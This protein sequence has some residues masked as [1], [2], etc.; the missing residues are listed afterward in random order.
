MK[1]KQIASGLTATTYVDEQQGLKLG[2]GECYV[3][4][5]VDPVTGESPYS[6]TADDILGNKM[7]Y[8]AS[9]DSANCS[10]KGASFVM[11]QTLNGV[12]SPGRSAGTSDCTIQRPT[13]PP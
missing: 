7:Y 3:V 1:F 2:Q 9:Y 10:M 8:T 4:T 13:R 5:A 12:T 6:N 11:T